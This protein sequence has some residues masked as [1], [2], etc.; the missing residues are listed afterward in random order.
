MWWQI[1]CEALA[2]EKRLLI[3][4]G[5]YSRVVEVHA[6]GTTADH[7]PIMRA[8]QVRG[9]SHSGSPYDWRHF[10]LDSSWQYAI[11]D[12]RSEAPRPGYK[13]DHSLFAFIHCQI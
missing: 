4:F 5:E 10:Q 7:K 1:A 3:T 11:L 9:G 13:R 12:E 2:N 6:I 8:W